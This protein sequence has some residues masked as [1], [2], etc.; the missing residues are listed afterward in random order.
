[1]FACSSYSPYAVQYLGGPSQLGVPGRGRAP[2]RDALN[3]CHDPAGDCRR[4]RLQDAPAV[5]VARPDGRRAAAGSRG[6]RRIPRPPG[7]HG[8]IG[9][10]Q[11]PSHQKQ[12]VKLPQPPDR[13][14]PP[15]AWRQVHA[16]AGRQPRLIMDDMHSILAAHLLLLELGPPSSIPAAARR[17]PCWAGRCSSQAGLQRHWSHTGGQTGSGGALTDHAGV[18]WASSID[19][20][21]D[22][23]PAMALPLAAKKDH[24]RATTVSTIGVS[25][26]VRTCALDPGGY[27]P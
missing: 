3:R 20:A 23:P 16:S 9:Q 4:T 7:P 17:M 19:S 14:T 5:R 18:C 25:T 26:C 15:A 21:G 6:R 10:S 11:C 1:M 22:E 27:P 8:R 2:P 12:L 13:G 24:A